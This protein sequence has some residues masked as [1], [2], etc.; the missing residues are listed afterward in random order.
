MF[1]QGRAHKSM[2]NIEEEDMQ[3][4]FAKPHN[5]MKLQALKTVCIIVVGLMFLNYLFSSRSESECAILRDSLRDQVEQLTRLRVDY[6]KLHC[7][8][9]GIGPTGGFCVNKTHAD[10][11]G[12]MHWDKPVCSEM[13][14]MMAHSSV[15]DLG[16]GLGHYGRCLQAN[17][18]SISWLG[19][20]GSEGIED[21]T[22]KQHL[23]MQEETYF[24]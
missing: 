14:K 5:S 1:V 11:G 13:S 4:L 17:E 6:G 7:K 16:C 22:G 24:T 10:V 2:N 9:H 12:N 15:L 19:Y 20:D 18:K 23:C 8:L 21:A 3:L